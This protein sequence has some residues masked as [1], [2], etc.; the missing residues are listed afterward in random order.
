VILGGGAA[1]VA[2]AYWLS[3]QKGKYDITLY[4][5]GWR[6]GGKCASGRDAH[7]GQRIEEH[8]LHV[9]M[10]CYQNAFVTM[11][12]CY[13]DWRAIKADPRNPFQTWRDAFVPQRQVSLMERD[14]PGSPHAWQPWNFTFPQLPGEPGDGSR[15]D[16]SGF[17]ERSTDDC[18]LILRM[19][20][21]LDQYVPSSAPFKQTL[22]RALEELREAI[23]GGPGLATTVARVALERAQ[24]DIQRSLAAVSGGRGP[25]PTGSAQDSSDVRAVYTESS[26]LRRL[27]IL[28]DL[29]V[30]IG[31][32]YLF[33]IFGRGPGAYEALNTQD[34]REWLASYGASPAS[35][36]AAPVRAFYDL[37]FAAVGGD[38]NWGGSMAAGVS[39]RAQMEMSLGYRNSPLWK[40]AAGMGDTIFTPF[41]DV[42]QERGVKIAFFSRV[43]ALR[44]C[45]A[46]RLG[47]I[48]IMVQ[49]VTGNGAPYQP[50]VR[51]N[52]LDCWPNQ[53]DWDQLQ[54][55]CALKAELEAA[56]VDFESTYCTVSTG[57]PIKLQVDVDFDLAIVAMP[58][59]SL[60]QPAAGL[61]AVNADWERA[62]RYGSSAG[63]QSLQ[64]WMKPA[65]KGLGWEYGST[66]LTAF[67]E[68]CDSWGDMSQVIPR[69]A[70][71]GPAPGSI[72]YFCGRLEIPPGPVTPRQMKAAVTRAADNWLKSNLRILWPKVSP[73]PLTDPNI[74]GRYDLAN[75]DLSDRYVTTP[76]GKNVASRFDP[77]QPAGFNNLY[78]VGD[79]TRTRF[80]GGCF[81]SALESAMLASRGIS[82][83]PRIIKTA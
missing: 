51:V 66:V 57:P 58:P 10:G 37:A 70:W 12:A 24:T 5:Q 3:A 21:W 61:V 28:A 50:L 79:W 54:N 27:A 25:T 82:G 69:E 47:E 41:Y 49:A 78:V 67:A 34:F 75:F 22:G 81:E 19:A 31:L 9:L 18:A 16:G 38:Q 32:G 56:G 17:N 68:P 55:G 8:G 35:L 30:A 23:R 33:D 45:G 44:P 39:L 73:D 83:H 76:C 2:A 20:E 62:L 80:S 72:A 29:G 15:T 26:E 48:D 77:A 65:L 11:R 40:M 52:E 42:L 7:N 71:V 59:D 14:G 4:T 46:D 64:L 13:E 6:L 53:P 63:T 1:G 60:R 74:L 36:A 43:T